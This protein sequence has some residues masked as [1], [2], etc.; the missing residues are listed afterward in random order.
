MG[1]SRVNARSETKSICCSIRCKF[2]CRDGLNARFNNWAEHQELKPLLSLSIN[3]ISFIL[4]VNA[5]RTVAETFV[6]SG[7]ATWS[8]HAW[9]QVK[10]GDQQIA[11]SRSL[12]GLAPSLLLVADLQS[13]PVRA[14]WRLGLLA[15][16]SFGYRSTI[17]LSYTVHTLHYLLSDHFLSFKPIPI[18]N[19]NI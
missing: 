14:T 7:W 2:I 16:L 19:L 15:I 8:L 4:M 13:N 6:D 18:T 3:S 5:A 9:I 17:C 1:K 11:T 10:P 12:M